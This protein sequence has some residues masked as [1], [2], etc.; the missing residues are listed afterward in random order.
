MAD[1]ISAAGDA[2]SDV[3]GKAGSRAGGELKVNCT[4]GTDAIVGAR[5]TVGDIAGHAASSTADS[6]ARIALSAN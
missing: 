6:E 4:G 5:Q 1:I 3:A 2:V